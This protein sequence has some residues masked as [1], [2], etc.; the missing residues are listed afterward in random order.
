MIKLKIQLQK[1]EK[2]SQA[3]LILWLDGEFQTIFTDSVEGCIHKAYEIQKV[4]PISRLDIT[5][6]AILQLSNFATFETV[7]L[8]PHN[9]FMPRDS[10]LNDSAN[11]LFLS[12]K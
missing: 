5:N 6:S 10:E 4:M 11:G 8:T 1:I 7:C 9:G 12:E 3:D 2:G